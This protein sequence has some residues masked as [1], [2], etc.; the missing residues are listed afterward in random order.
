MSK[1]PD[2]TQ[3][4]SIQPSSKSASNDR[5]WREQLRSEAKP[6][7]LIRK[8]DSSIDTSS[9]TPIPLHAA[10][11]L[12][13]IFRHQYD[14]LVRFC[15]GRIRNP[16]DAEDLVQEAFLSVRRAYADKPAEELRALL[17]TSLRNL[18]VNYLKSGR[19]RHA[20]QSEE[21]GELEG[22][23]ACQRTPTPEQQVM[24]RERLAIAEETIAAM[25]PRKRDAL[26]LH[27]FEG[28]TY[29]EI[30]RRLSVSPTTVKTDIAEA[31]AEIAENLSGA[32]KRSPAKG[33]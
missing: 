27:R 19:I 8:S 18:T 9:P 26:R 31:I 32:A 28:L 11:A 7:S 25:K 3:P 33:Q 6:S 15:R 30:A 2:Q 23:L 17:F 29:D 21:I 13:H 14:Q 5:D 24:D 12:S 1:L 10:D 16:A 4:L 22:R 20:R